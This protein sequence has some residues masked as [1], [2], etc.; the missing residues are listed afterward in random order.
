M[1]GKE[2]R[3]GQKI[4]RELEKMAFKIPGSSKLAIG[5]LETGAR[6][7][8]E[9]VVGRL[10]Q[11]TTREHWPSRGNMNGGVLSVQ[12][13]GLFLDSV[14]EDSEHNVLVWPRSILSSK[15]ELGE[16]I[17]SARP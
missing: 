2:G 6:G 14:E 15:V 10:A 17:K 5:R 13:C 8:L 1:G 3:R 4:G 9:W 12:Y 16:K 11:H 7:S